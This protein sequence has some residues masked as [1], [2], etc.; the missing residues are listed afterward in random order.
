MDFFAFF[1][2]FF[3]NLAKKESILYFLSHWTN[4]NGKLREETKTLSFT[5]F[6]H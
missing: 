2:V 1:Y 3:A 6:A 4:K 5:H